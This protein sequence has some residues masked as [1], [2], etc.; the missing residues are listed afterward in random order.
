MKIRKLTQETSPKALALLRQSFPNSNYEV[1]VVERLHH[2]RDQ[3]AKLFHEW[4]CIH[5][6]KI[7]AYIG[8][9]NA[10]DGSEICGLHLAP[11]AVKP[12]FQSQGIGTELLRFALRQESIKNKTIFTLGNPEFYEKFGFVLCTT[13]LSPFAKKRY[14][15]LSI[16]NNT[17]RQFTVGYE[18]E[19]SR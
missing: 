11:F 19:F 10:F 3:D 9:T 17:T 6:N 2:N 12:E 16:R 13:V 1:K 4:A 18:P 15:L 14:R 7:V 5:T 8:F